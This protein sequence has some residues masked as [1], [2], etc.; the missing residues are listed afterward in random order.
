MN[1]IIAIVIVSMFVP[2]MLAALYMNVAARRR[3]QTRWVSSTI[4][5]TR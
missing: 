5:R 3:K 2:M 4:R 1:A